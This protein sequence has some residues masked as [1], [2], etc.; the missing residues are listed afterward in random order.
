VQD[1]LFP[2]QRGA[3]HAPCVY[4]RRVVHYSGY[5]LFG[6]EVGS[7]ALLARYVRA[8]GHA[9]TPLTAAGHV[10]RG[11]DE[12]ELRL[13]RPQQGHRHYRG[14]AL[15][16]LNSLDLS[17]LKTLGFAVMPTEDEVVRIPQR[18]VGL[19]TASAQQLEDGGNSLLDAFVSVHPLGCV[20]FHQTFARRSSRLIH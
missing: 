3:G 2:L 19:D 7:V 10:H 16:G 14:A 1:D 11:W 4:V 9:P 6:I 13:L 17:V 15:G 20:D 5:G 18:L 8:T 12:G